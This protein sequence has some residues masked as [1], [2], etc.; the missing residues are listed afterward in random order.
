MLTGPATSVFR[1]GL[2]FNISKV[3]VSNFLNVRRRLFLHDAFLQLIFIP[4]IL[5]ASAMK[6]T[7]SVILVA[8]KFSFVLDLKNVR[9]EESAYS[10]M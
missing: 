7:F 4:L 8:F 1:L 6:Y 9:G 10:N 2:R 5:F 3:T